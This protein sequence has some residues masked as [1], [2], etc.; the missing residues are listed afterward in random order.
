MTDDSL[1]LEEPVTDRRS[2]DIGIVCTQTLEV[3]PLLKKLDRVRKYVD[4]GAVFRGGFLDEVIR[5]AIVEAG[6]GFAGNREVTQTLIAE[7]HPLWVLSVGFS[8]PLTD[9][10]QSGD[11]CLANEIC[12]THGNSLPV[13]GLV[14]ESKR[15][16]VGRTVTT[17]THPRSSEE[18]HQLR[19]ALDAVAVDTT[20]LAVAQACQSDDQTETPVRFLSVRAVVGRVDDE[21]TDQAMSSVFEPPPVNR[22]S[23]FRQISGKFRREPERV[24]WEKVT[25]EATRNLNRFLLSLIRK[26]AK[27]RNA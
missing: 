16:R 15:I 22:H 20:S 2:A 12:D 11:L 18:R 1:Q 17:D 5:I 3:R 19:N 8:S 24:V 27:K 4:G 21:L 10:L 6:T 9:D 7:H 14:A 13:P 23:V 26:L 25:A